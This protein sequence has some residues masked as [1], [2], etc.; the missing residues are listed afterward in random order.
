MF[1]EVDYLMPPV[2]KE[3]SEEWLDSQRALLNETLHNFNVRAK[4]VNVTQGR[5]LPGLRFNLS[6]G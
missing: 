4:V 5:P 6:P 3:M 2:S 1:P